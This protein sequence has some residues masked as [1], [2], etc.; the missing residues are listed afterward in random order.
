[1]VGKLDLENLVKFTL[2]A[3]GGVIYVTDGQIV[4]PTNSAPKQSPTHS[5]PSQNTTR[6]INIHRFATDVVARAAAIMGTLATR[7]IN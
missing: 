3:I 1:M 7:L 5:T 2:D 4:H 6:T